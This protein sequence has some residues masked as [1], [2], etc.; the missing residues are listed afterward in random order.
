MASK[1][2][3]TPSDPFQSLI[4]LQKFLKDGS[5]YLTFV[6]IVNS[7]NNNPQLSKNG[8]KF[9][10]YAEKMPLFESDR[11][12]EAITVLLG[13]FS[14]LGIAI[15]KQANI[16]RLILKRFGNVN[17]EIGVKMDQKFKKLLL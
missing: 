15:P 14:I 17:M 7:L 2:P 12:E 4:E 8:D 9:V 3:L 13:L 5:E 10:V 1:I 11:V 16:V 6:T